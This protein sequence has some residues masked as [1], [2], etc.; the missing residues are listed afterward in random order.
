[1]TNERIQTVVFVR[2]GVALHN[3]HANRSL[4]DPCF[5]DSPLVEAGKLQAVG[6]GIKVTEWM[7]DRID[8]IIVSPLSRCIETAFAGFFPG[9]YKQASPPR[10]VCHEDVREA[11]GMHY[12]DKRREKS[13]LEVC[14]VMWLKT[15]V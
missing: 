7:E 10:F 11:Y 9:S 8:L 5:V 12:P 15:F 1:M 13:T 6:M 4:H 2:H 14:L 3:L